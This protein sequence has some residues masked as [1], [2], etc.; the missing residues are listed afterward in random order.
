[1][2]VTVLAALFLFALVLTAFFGYKYLGKKTTAPENINNEKCSICRQK[3]EKKM[4]IERQIGD[5]KLLYFC[6][7]CIVRLYADLGIKN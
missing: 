3:F 5:Y 1:M 6:R 4:L 2:A 7:E